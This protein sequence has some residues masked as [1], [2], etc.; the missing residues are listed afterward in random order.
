MVTESLEELVKRYVVLGKRSATGFHA[1]KCQVCNDHSPR[2]GFKFGSD[3]SLGYSC[4]NCAIKALYD[5]T[6]ARRAPSK[7]L[8]RILGAFGV[9]EDEV[10][11]TVAANFFENRGLPAPRAEH[12][13]KQVGLP[14]NEC[15]LPPGCVSVLADTSPWCEVARTYLEGR[16][17]PPADYP[18]F[19]T[20]HQEHVGR[21][22]VPYLFRDKVIYWQGRALDD[23]IIPKYKNSIGERSNVL[24]NMDELYRYSDEPLYVTE[25]FTD[26]L[27]IGKNAVALLGSSL[28]EFQAGELTRIAQRRRVVFVLDKNYNGYKL[29][30]NVLELGAEIE[31]YVTVLPDNIDD[32]NDGLRKNGKLWLLN[33]LATNQWR[34][35]TARTNLQV[36]CDSKPPRP[37]K[38][39]R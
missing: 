2:G 38:T 24:F 14:V 17:L 32:S 30:Q 18:Y 6:T 25:G 15:Q 5:P 13:S 35:L 1:V 11:R 36:R 23:S 21:L 31:W 27:S 34:G 29:G 7:S 4:F 8:L 12:Q 39:R 3:G 33:Y 19:I 16:R 10:K 9:P 37:A 26:A 28:S 20:E 22:I